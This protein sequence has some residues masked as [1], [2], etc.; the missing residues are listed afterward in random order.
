MKRARG[1]G[2]PNR[3][4]ESS[5]KH[6]AKT[7]TGF[8]RAVSA[9]GNWWA[10]AVLL[11]G[12]LVT[13]LAARHH[14][15]NDDQNAKQEFHFACAEIQLRIE[16]RL[17]AH[18]Q[19][20]RAGVAFFA[21]NNGVT[22]GEWR[23]FAARQKISRKLP[24]IQGLGF[25]R[26]IPREQLA[27]HT[28]E[29]RDEGFPDY[30]IRPE[31]ERETYSSIIYLE[32]FTDRNLRAFGY[33]MLSEPVRRAA[34][35]RARDLDEVA[36]SGKVT[37]VQETGK[38]VQAGTLMFAPVY[39]TGMPYESVAERRAA[40]FGWVYSPYRMKDLMEG[41]LGRWE[42]AGQKQ[43][44]LKIYDGG[45]ASP[46]NLLYDSQPGGV[47]EPARTIRLEQLIK[48]DSAGCRWL[49]SFSGSGA[50]SHSTV[51]LIL[52]GGTALSLLLAALVLTLART[53]FAARRMA[54]QLTADLTENKDR[55]Q[56][57]ID[58]ASEYVW[59]MDLDGTFTYV[60][61]RA[62]DVL[63]RP[64]SQLLGTKLF[65]I[66]PEEDLAVLPEFF[67]AQAE[68]KEPF[69]NLIHRALLPDGS[70]KHQKI[71]GQPVVSESGEVRG[72]VGMAADITEEEKARA[73]L[74]HDRER[75]ETFFEVAIDLLCIFDL[76]CKFVR[77]SR[78]WED[79]TG[80]S[81]NEIEG[82]PFMDNVHPDDIA[83]TREEFVQVLTGKPLT[84]FVNRYRAGTGE[85]RSIEWRAKL[86]RGSV[87]AAAR[88]VTE[89][90]TAEEALERALERE[91]QTT[92][93]KS[94]LVSMA[95]HEFRTPLAS[96]RLAAE[97]LSNSRDRLDEAAIQRGL[98]TILDS[99]DFMTEVV[100][101]VL[102]LSSLGSASPTEPLSKIPLA[103]FLRQIAGDFCFP[104][105]NP[106]LVSFAWNGVP[107]LARGYPILLKR[108]LFNLLGNAVKYAPPGSPIVLRLRRDGRTAVIQVEDH[109]IG[110]PDAEVPFLYDLFYRASNSTGIPGTGLGLPLVFEAMHRMDGNVE[111]SQRPGGGSIFTLRLPLAEGGADGGPDPQA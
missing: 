35:E 36:L 104:T 60:S 38:D 84:G 66:L 42:S 56:K 76:D 87:F 50:L 105:G 45:S 85:W 7:L 49:L 68:K 2:R 13:A 21:D 110:I 27:R 65:D 100:T 58:S 72:F 64:V 24:G 77:V 43:I 6:P 73:Q 74:A 107:V 94:R 91:R 89:S 51:W 80:R 90:K 26:L 29:I 62:A 70:V 15:M 88:D 48:S 33:D 86:I 99:T 19:I 37:L 57:I 61:P 109:G 11:A 96:I 108:A 82:S 81:R 40:L 67:K 12:L 34:L 52:G 44:R 111:Y 83:S 47:E 20:L 69:E 59:E 75:I 16:E 106:D 53:G 5:I 97:L 10:L 8:F 32:P 55:L 92:E 14:E 101:D 30:R 98:Q 39:R 18:E 23:D 54:E 17:R 93:I 71:T 78:A 46:E 1:E 95:S 63:G 9:R 41:I 25:A 4:R 3:S 22:R 79:L 31:G 102:D 28:Q 103:E